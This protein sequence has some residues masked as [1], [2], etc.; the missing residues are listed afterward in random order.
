MA[1]AQALVSWTW[2]RG[3]GASWTSMRSKLHCIRCEHST[4]C[5]QGRS[6]IAWQHS[7]CGAASPA[8]RIG[9]AT[10]STTC[11]AAAKHM[12]AAA[13]SG[14]TLTSRLPT[15]HLFQ[16]RCLHQ[17]PRHPAVLA[18]QQ[19][20]CFALCHAACHHSATLTE[21]PTQLPAPLSAP[22][23]AAIRRRS[24]GRPARQCG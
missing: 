9:T 16:R 11:R 8:T 4:H 5:K 13:A 21:A 1:L 15:A 17:A 14:R 6:R 19:A 3:P 20:R 7:F 22:R 12:S 2:P 10:P 23:A 24:C 18:Q